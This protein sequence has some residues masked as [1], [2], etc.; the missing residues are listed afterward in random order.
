MHRRRRALRR[1]LR[2]LTLTHVVA[3][4]NLA[5]TVVDI[6]RALTGHN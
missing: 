4:A 2:K 6:V 1:V 5:K 3:V